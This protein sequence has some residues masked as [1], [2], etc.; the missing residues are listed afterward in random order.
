MPSD[1]YLLSVGDISRRGDG[2]VVEVFKLVHPNLCCSPGVPEE[3]VR[4]AIWGEGD[5]DEEKC[6]NMEF[7]L[8]ISLAE[9]GPWVVARDF[10][11]DLA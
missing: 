10:F 11:D 6:N 4:K 3:Q 2:S 8:D 1:W 5:R 7:G 9:A